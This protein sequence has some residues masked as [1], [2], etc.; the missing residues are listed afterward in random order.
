MHRQ[1]IA[2]TYNLLYYE[3]IQPQYVTHL[4]PHAA[5]GLQTTKPQRLT[6]KI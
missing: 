4:A 3:H 6:A 2:Q 1:L 5:G